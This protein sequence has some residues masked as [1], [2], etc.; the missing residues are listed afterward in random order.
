MWRMG[1]KTVLSCL[2]RGDLV[3]KLSRTYVL[4]VR[5][6]M[7]NK[8]HTLNYPG[9]K[10]VLDVKRDAHTFTDIPVRHQAWSGWPRAALRDERTT[11]ACAG[12]GYPLHALSVRRAAKDNKRIVI[13]V[14]DSDNSSVE[15]FEDASQTF[16]ED[17]I[18]VDVETKRIQPLNNVEDETAG[19]IHFADEFTNRYGGCHPEFFPGSLDEA[20]KEACLRPAKDKRLLAV[21]LHHD[22]S[23]LS[24]VFC[25]QLLGFESVL[26]W[27]N[28]HFVVWG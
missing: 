19:C 22:G 2:R 12:I 9:S 23:V 14:L 4:Q 16:T 25:T 1:R 17:D 20:V 11:L 18:F 5:D 7:T 8:T 15:E 27:P 28:A 13:D 21:Y 26:Q 3:E 10:T 24:N 6:E